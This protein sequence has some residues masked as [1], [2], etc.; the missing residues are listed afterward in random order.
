MKMIF[1]ALTS[2]LA[3]SASADPEPHRHRPRRLDRRPR[4]RLAQLR[5]LLE[6]PRARRERLRRGGIL[7]RGAGEHV[8]HAD[9]RDGHHPHH[10]QPVQDA[11]RRAP[12]RRQGPLQRHRA[13]RVVQRDQRLRRRERLVL[14]LGARAPLRLRLGRRVGATR[15]RR[16]AQ[17]LEPRPLRDPEHLRR[18]GRVRHILAGGPGDSGIREASTC[19]AT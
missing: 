6:Q 18:R 3:F 10:R 7:H 2:A 16:A 13:G 14:R 17:E 1:A 15:R 11:H 4:R 9:R 19:S 12:P 8:H 5:L